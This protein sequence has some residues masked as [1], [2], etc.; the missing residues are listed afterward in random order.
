MFF[1]ISVYLVLSPLARGT[2]TASA[3]NARAKGL[4]PAHTG[5]I[6]GQQTKSPAHSAHPRSHGEHGCCGS[7]APTCWG[8]SPLARG[9]PIARV[10]GTIARGLIPAHAGNT[11]HCRSS[12]LL[13]W[14]HPHSRGEH[15]A[16][17]TLG[18]PQAGSS[19]HTQ[20]IFKI[21]T[22]LRGNHRL[23]PA[24]AGNIYSLLRGRFHRRVHPH[25]RGE[26]CHH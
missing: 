20:G 18:N 26:H 13:A 7:V 23:I 11:W 12:L 4:I 10:S 24:H 8:S 16:K 9:T 17:V 15:R 6:H 3:S 22:R 25:S 14:A 2:F 19:P 1:C 5:T 21:L